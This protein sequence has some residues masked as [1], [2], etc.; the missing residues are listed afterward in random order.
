MP[1]P[2]LAPMRCPEMCHQQS[3]IA[4]KGLVWCAGHTGGVLRI[5]DVS[6]HTP[7]HVHVPDLLR[8]ILPLAPLTTKQN[9]PT[10]QC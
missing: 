10:S 1:Q 8:M 3:L 5:H 7:C 2:A 6:L 9:A 4:S